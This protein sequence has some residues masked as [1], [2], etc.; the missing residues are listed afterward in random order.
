MIV[1]VALVVPPVAQIGAKGLAAILTVEAKNSL[2]V[3]DAGALTTTAVEAILVVG[4][5]V[6]AAGAFPVA[7]GAAE[8]EVAHQLGPEVVTL[9]SRG[10][11]VTMPN[12]APRILAGAR[13]CY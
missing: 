7:A 2:G 4:R 10:P 9:I 8:A 11:E 13:I 3:S 1:R 6:A 12:N 5:V